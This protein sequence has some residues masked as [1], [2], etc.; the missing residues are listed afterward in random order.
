[1]H[2]LIRRHSQAAAVVV[3]Q[4]GRPNDLLERLAADPAF[5]KI[6]IA[7]AIKLET[8]FG[9]APQQVDEF[10]ASVVAPVLARYPRR[11]A[12]GQLRV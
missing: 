11:A 7:G 6:D 8:F 1:M 5:A 4:G 3:K 9:R 10:L 2:E 12:A